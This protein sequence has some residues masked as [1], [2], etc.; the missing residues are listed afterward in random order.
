MEEN[1]HIFLH[2]QSV[3]EIAGKNRREDRKKACMEEKIL[4]KHITGLE[5]PYA[6]Q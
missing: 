5:I 4:L 1:C 3:P 2:F 6:S